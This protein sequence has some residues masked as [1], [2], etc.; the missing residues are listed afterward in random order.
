MNWNLK[1]NHL[2]TGKLRHHK[3]ETVYSELAQDYEASK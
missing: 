3:F 2:T 1:S